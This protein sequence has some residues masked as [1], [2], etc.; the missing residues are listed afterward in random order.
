MHPKSFSHLEDFLCD[1]AKT[2][3]PKLFSCQSDPRR[4]LIPD[5][6]PRFSVEQSEISGGAQE[7]R[8]G[9]LRDSPV[10]IARTI[11]YRNALISCSPKVD[12][13]AGTG[14]SESN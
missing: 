9:V 2:D 4:V 6:F 12:V 11:T 3:K 8:K 7:Q 5:A 14:A 10:G 1:P 13:I